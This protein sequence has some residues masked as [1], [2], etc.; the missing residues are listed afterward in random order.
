M[1]GGM[2]GFFGHFSQRFNAYGPFKPNG[3]CGYHPESLKRAFRTHRRFWRD[4][5]LRLDMSP[6]NS[7]AG[8]TK[9][10]CLAASDKKHFVFFGEDTDWITIDLNGMPGTQPVI[11]VDA[12]TDYREID[13]GKLSA[14]IH[15]IN[16]DRISDW[17][18][19]VGEFGN[20]GLGQAK[21]RQAGITL[22]SPNT[23]K[24]P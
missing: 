16:L 10:Y 12:K 2:G 24:S 13:M 20:A 5:R 15:T 9:A 23:E 14:G 17:A 4:G 6:D 19:A 22:A 11:S 1:A 7:R 8:G 21:R 18:L 3:P